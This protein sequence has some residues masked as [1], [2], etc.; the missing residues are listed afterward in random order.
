MN[1]DSMNV[2]DMTPGFTFLISYCP[3]S[4]VTALY[5][6]PLR[7]TEISSAGMFPLKDTFPV[8]FLMILLIM[9][10]DVKKTV[11]KDKFFGNVYVHFIWF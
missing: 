3:F 9:V 2:N 1:S 7:V 11:Q 5:F 8:T 4:L 6:V 10:T